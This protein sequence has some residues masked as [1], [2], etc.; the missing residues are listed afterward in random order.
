MVG[1]VGEFLILTGSFLTFRWWTVVAVSGVILAALYLLWAYQRVF[2][3]ESDEDNASI[4]DLRVAEGFVLAP[5]VVLI[6]VMGLYP[7]P[8]IERIEPAVDRLVRHVEANSDYVEPRVA[9]EGEQIVP[10]AERRA[11]DHGG[12]AGDEHADVTSTDEGADHEGGE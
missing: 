5:L 2:H 3:G 4:P 12:E 6:V 7:K 11:D 10:A 9:T 8:F 1:F